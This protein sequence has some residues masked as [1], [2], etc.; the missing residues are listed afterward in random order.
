MNPTDLERV[1]DGAL[2]AL[3]SPRA[4]RTLLPA[5]MLAV[6]AAA[7]RPWY[8]RPWSSWPA[9]WQAVSAMALLALLAVGSFAAPL[10]QP[11][12]L[13]LASGAGVVLHPATEVVADLETF[14]SVVEILRRTIAQ[15]VVGLGLTL[16]LMMLV[17]SLALGAAIGRVAL[18][19]AYRS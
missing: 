16:F 1:V 9:S 11:Y 4:P 2:K 13:P 6:R 10:L 3:P 5:V 15:S 7:L 19:G 8:A 18:G 14:I 12:L 17:T